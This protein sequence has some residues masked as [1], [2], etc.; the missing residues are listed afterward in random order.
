MIE[1]AA[2]PPRRHRGVAAIRRPRSKRGRIPRPGWT[3][4]SVNGVDVS[5]VGAASAEAVLGKR[6]NEERRLVFEAAPVEAELEI[7]VP[8]D[9][10]RSLGLEFAPRAPLVVE[11]VEDD[12]PLLGRV[13]VGARLLAV[14]GVD[15]SGLTRG[16]ARAVF[17]RLK[18]AAFAL[19]FLTEKPTAVRL[20]HV[21]FC[22][23]E[24]ER[25]A[26]VLAAASRFLAASRLKTTSVETLRD[27]GGDGV[28]IWYD[29]LDPENARA[30]VVAAVEARRSHAAP[31]AAGVRL[32]EPPAAP[33]GGGVHLVEPDALPRPGV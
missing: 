11:A 18:G 10:I 14:D 23:E 28:R 29:R 26:D 25:W 5:R 31:R 17:Q 22:R 12:S 21:D 1:G 27:A 24:G 2:E 16:E 7:A 8:G 15:L 30:D 20:A 3:L 9:R 6:S 4:L 19:K 32:V 33:A 13:A